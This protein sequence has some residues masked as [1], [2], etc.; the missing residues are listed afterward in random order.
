M[1]IKLLILFS[2]ITFISCNKKAETIETKEKTEFE[3]NIVTENISENEIKSIVKTNFPENTPFTITVSRDYGR[4]NNNEKYA[5]QL[6]YSYNSFV[7]NNHLDFN[8]K[9][10]DKKWLDEYETLRKENGKFDKTLTEIDKKTIKD[11]LEISILYTPKAEQSED[12]KKIIGINGENLTGKDVEKVSD[13]KVYNK[14]IKIYNKF[15]ND[16]QNL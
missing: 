4:K 8:F 9:V 11:T 13:F 2:I 7:K 1:K 15:K 3:V 10:D 5:G 6:Y 16:S 12:I 14:T